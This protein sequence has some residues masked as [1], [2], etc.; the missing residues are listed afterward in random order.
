M[1]AVTRTGRP[2]RT[3][4][5]CARRGSAAVTALELGFDAHELDRLGCLEQDMR[6]VVVAS[7][8]RAGRSG[9]ESAAHRLRG[10]PAEEALGAAFQEMITPSRSIATKASGALSS[11]RRVR[12]S[13]PARPGRARPPRAPRPQAREQAR[14][15]QT[16]DERRAHGQK[17]ADHGAVGLDHDHHDPVADGRSGPRARAPR[18]AGRSR[19]RTAPS[20]CRDRVEHRGLDEVVA[21]VRITVPVARK[22]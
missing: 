10:R 2:M 14:D 12:A 19:R 5:S 18:A 15:Q 22:A 21:R 3:S 16:G 7:R 8:T 20:T 4:R 11:T 17:P 13:L 1:K 6:R 9:S